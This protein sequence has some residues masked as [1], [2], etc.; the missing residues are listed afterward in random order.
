MKAII[1][2][3]TLAVLLFLLF[4]GPVLNSAGAAAASLFAG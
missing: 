4:A 3:S 1:G 2:G